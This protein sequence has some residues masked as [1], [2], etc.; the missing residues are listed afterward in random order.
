MNKSDALKDGK[1]PNKVMALDKACPTNTSDDSGVPYALS[2]KSNPRK[3]ILREGCA[4]FRH[5]QDNEFPDMIATL[6]EA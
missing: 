6:I 5:R 2:E 4:C 3:P 1:S